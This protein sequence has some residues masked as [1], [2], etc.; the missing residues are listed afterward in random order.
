MSRFED[1]SDLLKA[2]LTDVRA[3]FFPELRSAQICC[4]FDLKKR[5][6]GGR[7]VLAQV[8]KTNDLLRTL[9]ADDRI[10]EGFDYIIT[11]D[12]VAWDNITR[13]DRVRILRHELRHCYVDLD[14]KSPYKIA[15]HDFSDFHEEVSLN[16]DDPTWCSRVADLTETIYEQIRDQER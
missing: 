5:T 4:L 1:A 12:K 14:A 8:R 3:D 10:E 2:L 16:N 13:D 15:E 6:K 9:T 11:V 7:M